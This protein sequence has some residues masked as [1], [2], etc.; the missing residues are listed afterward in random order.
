MSA[1]IFNGTAVK[2]LKNI[3]RFK[4]GT[5]LEVSKLVTTDNTKTLTNKTIVAAN[6]TITTAASG[7]LTSTELNAALSELQSDIDTKVSLTAIFSTN[8]ASGTTVVASLAANV[9]EFEIIEDIGEFM[10]LRDGS[11]N[12]LAYLPLGGG[13]VKISISSGT[14]LK[15]TIEIGGTISVGSNAIN[16][17][18]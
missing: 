16:F 1:A 15:L 5:D 17:L 14:A 3:L 7:N 8:S 2:I 18:G 6:N 4:D 9:S 10:T 11:D 12:V 13:R